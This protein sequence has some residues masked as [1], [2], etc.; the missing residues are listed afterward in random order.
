MKKHSSLPAVA[1]ALVTL[2]I[3]PLHAAIA[4][5]DTLVVDFGKTGSTTAGNWNNVAI[6]ASGGTFPLSASGPLLADM[7]RYSDGSPTGA[8]LSTT[9]ITSGNP[10]GI[11]GATVSAVS[12]SFPVSGS[13]PS[14]AQVDTS[15]IA[16]GLVTIVIDNLDAAWTYNLT[17][18]SKLDAARNS[19]DIVVN[20]TTLAVDP[21]DSPYLTTWSNIVPN[22]SNEIVISFPNAGVGTSNVLTQHINA[23]ELT[24]VP[25]PSVTLFTS[26]GVLCFLNRRRRF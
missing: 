22:G 18:F 11:G 7:I 21:N 13:I 23:F 15:F 8:T 26:L 10:A 25:E 12:A 3:A 17:I 9:G 24:A 19:Q 16:N 20:G 4:L 1:A 2:S 5:Y 6:G 14:N